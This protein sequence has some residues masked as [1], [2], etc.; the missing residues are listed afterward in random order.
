MAKK[1]QENKIILTEWVYKPNQLISA[2][3]YEGMEK[4]SK[5]INLSVNKRKIMNVL[6]QAVHNHFELG[7]NGDLFKVSLKDLRYRTGMENYSTPNVVKEVEGMMSVA[8]ETK[9]K[10]GFDRFILFTRIKYD[11]EDYVNFECNKHLTN[12]IKNEYCLVDEN[13]DVLKLEGNEKK[14]NYY[15]RLNI[16]LESMFRGKEHAKALIMYEIAVH[17]ISNIKKYG[18]FVKD[19][20]ELLEIMGCVTYAKK[21]S[22]VINKIL[23]PVVEDLKRVGIQLFYKCETKSN[24][25]IKNIR[26]SIYFSE[27]VDSYLKYLHRSSNGVEHYWNDY[28]TNQSKIFFFRNEDSFNE[29]K[30]SKLTNIEYYT[31]DDNTVD[32]LEEDYY[33]DEELEI[34]WGECY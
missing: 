23:I 4:D 5:F 9:Y 26:F 17:N 21:N 20:T 29:Y 32:I 30:K 8:F 11:G 19:L 28:P 14:H 22:D 7:L 13:G 31:K 10:K 24:G 33:T 27:N 18:S 1:E 2:L 3:A 16:E 6:I 34:E 12:A 15:S 25:K